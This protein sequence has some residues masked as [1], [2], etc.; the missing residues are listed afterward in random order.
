MADIT[1]TSG[2][3]WLEK[4]QERVKSIFQAVNIFQKPVN[5]SGKRGVFISDPYSSMCAGKVDYVSVILISDLY[6]CKLI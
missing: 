1:G 5:I 2:S 6:V 4:I 3:S